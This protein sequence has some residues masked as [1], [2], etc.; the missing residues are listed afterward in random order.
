MIAFVGSEETKYIVSSVLS[1]GEWEP[2]PYSGDLN[3]LYFNL[4]S[5]EYSFYVID[6][7]YILKDVSEIAEN[8]SK[9][10]QATGIPH[11][12]IAI[13]YDLDSNLIKTLRGVGFRYFVTSKV[14]SGMK[15]ELR[16]CL[17]GIETTDGL[18]AM[19]K[20]SVSSQFD[21][22][23]EKAA[24]PRMM[25]KTVGFMGAQSRIGTTTQA[26]QFV[27]YLQS[28]NLQACYIE[29]GHQGHIETI[30]ELYQNAK[31]DT[32]SGK[33][34]FEQTDLYY[35]PHKV[36]D[37]L[38]KGYHVYVY[39]FGVFEPE[40]MF[41]FLEKDMRIA[42]CGSK[43]WEMPNNT[44]LLRR[45]Y[46]DDVQYLFSFTEKNLREPLL[47]SMRNKSKT[48]YFCEYCPSAF[49]WTAN[50]LEMQKS[51]LDKLQISVPKKR[52]R[53]WGKDRN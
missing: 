36:Q 33:I 32:D 18:N 14:L 19:E 8:F 42:V 23:P 50:Q 12:F 16:Q 13:E 21:K 51:L 46:E 52:R 3:T 27:K 47:K 35:D 43:P 38:E 49:S 1:E 37:L 34:T 17:D 29:A 22:T 15:D 7:E 2:V 40:K 45:L 53:F 48:T 20:I 31:Q 24:A 26:I 28:Q 30:P 44:E 25:Y 11:I 41:S 39:D 4:T 6:V 10:Y 9:L 5:K